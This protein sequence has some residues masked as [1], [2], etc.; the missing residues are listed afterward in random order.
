MTNQASTIIAQPPIMPKFSLKAGK[1]VPVF[2][3][4]IQ[5]CPT[6]STNTDFDDDKDNPGLYG[7]MIDGVG[8]GI[9]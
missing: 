9:I 7:N 5:P 1:F 3:F 8:D 6:D 4:V 2:S